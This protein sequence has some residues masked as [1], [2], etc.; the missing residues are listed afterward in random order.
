MKRFFTLLAIG[1]ASTI[2]LNAATG[3]VTQAPF[4]LGSGTTV[5]LTGTV[6]SF[7]T[8]GHL[9]ASGTY[10]ISRADVLIVT[11]TACSVAPTVTL[12]TGTSTGSASILTGT[13][14][15]TSTDALTS[16]QIA[17]SGTIPVIVTGTVANNIYLKV[18]SAATATALTGKALI[19]GTKLP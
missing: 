9:A 7:V 13:T 3:E 17:A 16:T 18:T 10:A 6:N 14:V 4:V 1:L 15:L 19:Q 12:V 11:S 5:A 8:V 2:N